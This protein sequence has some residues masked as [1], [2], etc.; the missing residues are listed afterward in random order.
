MQSAGF[1]FFCV[2]LISAVLSQYWKEQLLRYSGW[3][4]PL[5]SS[6]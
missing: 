2:T 6:I 3:I 4:L 5:Q 1:L